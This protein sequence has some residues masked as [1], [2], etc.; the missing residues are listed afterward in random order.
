M[1]NIIQTGSIQNI[2]KAYNFVPDKNFV[3]YGNGPFILDV[4]KN[5]KKYGGKISNVFEIAKKPSITKIKN[6]IMMS[7]SN[8]FLMVKGL[9]ILLYLKMK[10]IDVNYGV[11]LKKIEKKEKGNK[12]FL[13]IFLLQKKLHCGYRLFV[14][15]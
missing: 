10:S 5:I 1:P 6:L 11:R 15:W 8:P 13:K 7:L 12:M 4:S 9:V 2:I 14:C 3:V